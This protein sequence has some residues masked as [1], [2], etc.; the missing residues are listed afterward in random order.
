MEGSIEVDGSSVSQTQLTAIETAMETEL[1][2][3]CDVRTWVDSRRRLASGTQ[4]RLA[5]S[6]MF[7]VSLVMEKNS[8][9]SIT[10]FFSTVS[11]ELSVLVSS[12]DL[13]AATNA[14]LNDLTGGSYT[15]M[16][17]NS[18]TSDPDSVGFVETGNDDTITNE[19]KCSNK[20]FANCVENIA[21]NDGDFAYCDMCMCDEYE[22]YGG[23]GS[24]GSDEVLYAC[25]LSNSACKTQ[26][27]LSWIIGFVFIAVVACCSIAACTFV[28]V[29]SKSKKV[30]AA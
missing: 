27:R 6:I 30:Q 16:T 18:V 11:S 23:S 17:V 22:S 5:V 4:R 8:D 25:Y 19:G 29:R 13:T 28:C 1:G 24:C 7:A 10:N 15:P 14:A 9:L 12:G 21:D 3:G 20:V 2:R 26:M